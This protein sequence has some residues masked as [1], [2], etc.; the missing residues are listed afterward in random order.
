MLVCLEMPWR[1]RDFAGKIILFLRHTLALSCL[2]VVQ[3]AKNARLR[4]L[5]AKDGREPGAGRT[6]G[7]GLQVGTARVWHAFCGQG[8][9][10]GRGGVRKVRQALQ[11]MLRNRKNLPRNK[12]FLPRNF[13]F[14]RHFP[15]V[16]PRKKTRCRPVW[17]LK[18]VKM[19]RMRPFGGGKMPRSLKFS[20]TLRH[21]SHPDYP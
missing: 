21:E 13:S 16:S 20:V 11:M 12:F 4:V 10:R 6:S 15:T 17:R 5:L 7:W 8:V 9:G 1:H 2:F 3:R 14:L 18:Y 19:G